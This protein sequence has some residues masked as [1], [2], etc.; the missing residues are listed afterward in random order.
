MRCNGVP[1]KE[2]RIKPIETLNGKASHLHS[3][4]THSLIS[5]S[6]RKG[7]G[8]QEHRRAS[9]WR[10]LDAYALDRASNC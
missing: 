8:L 10:R 3:L 5:A 2:D 4:L 9:K 6:H 7:R 1:F